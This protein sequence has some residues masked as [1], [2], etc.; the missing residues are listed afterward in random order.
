MNQW[1]ASAREDL[2]DFYGN[3]DVNGDGQPDPSW[4]AQALTYI[5]PPYPMFWSWSPQPVRKLRCHRKVAESLLRVLTNIG[6]CFTKEY[7]ASHHLDQ[8]G[9][10]YNF[11]LIRGG[12][13][14]SLH[15][16]GAAIDLAPLQNL[17]GV[18]YDEPKGMMP[19]GV[20][21]LFKQEG[22]VWGGLWKR[23]DAQHF[24]ATS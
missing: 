24:Q 1:P 23:G 13:S 3:P 6:S 9:G 2:N 4:E 7:I 16:Y 19:M 18:A 17:L 11:R 5:V 14:L 20:V 15:S 12:N 22:W 8:C 10:C 21:H